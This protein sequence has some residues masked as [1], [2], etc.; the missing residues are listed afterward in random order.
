MANKSIWEEQSEVHTY[1]T[2]F[3]GTWKPAAFFRAMEEATVHHS[4]HLHVDYFTLQ[5]FGLAWV[6]ARSKIRFE[7]FPSAGTRLQVKTWPKGWSQKIFGMRDYTI[8]TENGQLC[9]LATTA[10]LLIDTGTRRFVKPEQLPQALPDNE[11]RFAMDENLEKL[12]HPP[13][14]NVM[15]NFQAHY[16][17]LD[18]MG[19]VNNAQYIDWIFDCLPVDMMRHQKP[20]WLQINYN[21]EVKP[22][23]NL[24]IKSASL[25]GNP[26]ISSFQGYNLTRDVIAFDAQVGWRAEGDES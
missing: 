11:G 4:A 17:S 1:E 9:A 20:Q 8:Q 7:Q 13:E 10:W 15:G 23:E 14:M 5:Q 19:H 22:D 3:L 25:S 24:V 16:S 26:D 18:L 12:V 6:L 2:D 21:N